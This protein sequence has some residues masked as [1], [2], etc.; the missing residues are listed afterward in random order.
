LRQEDRNLAEILIQFGF[1]QPGFLAE[2]GDQ[3]LEDYLKANKIVSDSQLK[4]AQEVLRDSTGATA[5]MAALE[6][7]RL[8]PSADSTM[9]VDVRAAAATPKNDIGPY[10]LVRKLGG[11]GMGEVWKAWEKRLKRYVAVKFILQAGQEQ[12]DQ[13]RLLRE[14]Q[15]AAK[16]E[17]PDIVPVYEL[18]SSERGPFIAMKFVEGETLDRANLSLKQ[19]AL[20]VRDAALALDYAHGQGVIHRDIK[21]QNILVETESPGLTTPRT[22]TRKII[23]DQPAKIYVMDFG[24]AKEQS[25]HTSMSASGNVLGTPA[26]MPPEQAWG[27]AKEADA[28]SDVYSL[29]ATLY[30]LVAGAPPYQGEDMMS[31]L[32]SVVRDDPLPPSRFNPSLPRDVQTIILKCLEKDPSR[33]Y[34]TAR[35]LAEDLNRWVTGEPIQA[36]PPSLVYRAWKRIRKNPAV[37]ALSTLLILGVLGA[38][39][40]GASLWW[41]LEQ[42]SNASIKA[43]AEEDYDRAIG[44]LRD[45]QAKNPGREGLSARMQVLEAKRRRKQQEAEGREQLGAA[46]A[47][48][49]RGEL[50]EAE[51]LL[52]RIVSRA[53]DTDAA[54]AA[55]WK[56]HDLAGGLSKAAWLQRILER[57]SDAQAHLRL[58]QFL[59]QYGLLAEALE[60]FERAG[61][62]GK[63]DAEWCRLLLRRLTAPTTAT[64]IGK[65][66]IDG[67]GREELFAAGDDGSITVFGLRQGALQP[68]RTETGI[69][70][71]A[72]ADHVDLNGDGSAELILSGGSVCALEL[73]SQPARKAWSSPADCALLCD[74]DGDAKLELVLADSEGIR[75]LKFDK[76]WRETAATL[77][78][79]PE[80]GVMAMAAAD[81]NG[82]GRPELIVASG[83]RLRLDLRAFNVQ[84]TTLR[85]MARRQVGPVS[86]I[87]A[88]DMDGNRRQELWIVRTHEHPHP[89]ICEDD[90]WLGPGGPQILKWE[91][92]RLVTAWSD[93]LIPR[94]APAAGLSGGLLTARTAAGPVFQCVNRTSGSLQLCFFKGDAPATRTYFRLGQAALDRPLVAAD[95]D[96]DG[97][98]ELV[99]GGRVLTAFGVGAA[100]EQAGPFSLETLA[101][102]AR[103]EGR[104]ELALAALAAA[105]AG[106]GRARLESALCR[107]ALG[108]H[109]GAMSILDSIAERTPEYW[110]IR[111][112]CAE[113][114]LDWPGAIEAAEALGESKRAAELRRVISIVPVIVQDMLDPLDPAWRFPE[115]LGVRQLVSSLRLSLAPGERALK[116]PIEWD[117]T[118]FEIRALASFRDA[119]HGEG[120]TFR[121]RATDG[122]WEV[123][124]GIVGRGSR[125]AMELEGS[126]ADRASAA[127]VD[128]DSMGSKTWISLLILPHSGMV[129]FTLGTPAGATLRRWSNRLKLPAAP[130][131]YELTIEGHQAP[132]LTTS[133]LEI[134]RFEILAANPQAVSREESPEEKADRA[135]VRRAYHE[136][137][138]L[139]A[140][141]NDPAGALRRAWAWAHAGDLKQAEG[142]LRDHKRMTE[143]QPSVLKFEFGEGGISRWEEAA[144]R[145][146]LEDEELARQLILES[147]LMD[148]QRYGGLLRRT[149]YQKYV[150]S[151][152][153]QWRE[154]TPLF[155]QATK[156]ALEDAQAWH[157]L[158]YCWLRQGDLKKAWNNFT[159][160]QALDSE[161]EKLYPVEGGPAICMAR[162][163]ALQGDREG[164]VRWIERSRALGGNMDIPRHHPAIRALLGEARLLELTGE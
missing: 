110:R 72:R 25:V 149:A 129:H 36:V 148:A 138:K 155:L 38:A 157:G 95:L 58:G 81:L 42:L 13:Q 52:H 93:A 6:K 50:K 61:A 83:P 23:P 151:G 11:G 94:E 119:Q 43:E 105:Q 144:A 87:A 28:R 67:D 31:V 141:R 92:G 84:G 4:Q 122:P 24:L 63:D 124:A 137:A 125:G 39:G 116:L 32:A 56:L 59:E 152:Q 130:G 55:C 163:C 161:V 114:A 37:F 153:R 97:K 140:D 108:D 120:V 103:E 12:A 128:W 134:F 150:A 10:L 126:V 15:V 136:A 79:T 80:D 78:K 86:A 2:V 46:E 54:V 75:L 35:E 60:Q 158:G 1:L 135:W 53:G 73:T 65:G 57:R 14:A 118:P 101:F 82:D 9:P 20:A 91:G 69:G 99:A 51:A 18:G 142:E 16:L 62:Q 26:Y 48:M 29:G 17:H 44:L 102:R 139:Y 117:G 147:G 8:A 109:A 21:P 100:T 3:P 64:P 113:A 71:F 121:L 33:R 146:M 22:A 7:T 127:P 68:V 74:L 98:D 49:A 162:I 112:R 160:S 104:N 145:L 34:P 115:P 47:M 19:K 156:V 131:K 164:T 66:D 88:L 133:E 132:W 41:E 107:E 90:P 5:L 106:G 77:L 76:E 70:S 30:R 45:L 27:R 96:G 89:L 159:Q 123:Q 111:L 154:A 85:E 143:T 40:Y